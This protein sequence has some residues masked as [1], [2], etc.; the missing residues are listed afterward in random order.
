MCPAWQL[1]APA[2]ES[3]MSSFKQHATS[4]TTLL[5]VQAA[6]GR[7]DAAGASAEQSTHMAAAAA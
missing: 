1:A 3:R 7:M 4:A 6:L 2:L 5:C